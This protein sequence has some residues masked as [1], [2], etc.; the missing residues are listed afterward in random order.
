MFK[1]LKLKFIRTFCLV[2][3]VLMMCAGL[4][5]GAEKVTVTGARV[6]V[7]AIA[8]LQ[9]EIVGQV[10]RG[11]VLSATGERRNGMVEIIPPDS[12]AAWIYGELVIGDEVAA[13][14][15]RV[16]SGPGIGFRSIGKISKGFKVKVLETGGD[17]L[18]ISPPSSCTVWISAEFVSGKSG[19]AAVVP[20]EVAAENSGIAESSESVRRG[21]VVNS[22]SKPRPVAV[23]SQP[24]SIKPPV[25]PS[26]PV[27]DRRA[28]RPHVK[29]SSD[30]VIPVSPVKTVE[31]SKPAIVKS[32][33][34]TL[35]VV[36]KLKLVSRAP[37]GNPIVVCGVVRTS[38]FLPLRRPG[39]YRLVISGSNKAAKTG[40]YLIGDKAL[41]AGA[42]GKS[43]KVTGKKYWVQGVREPVVLV[44]EFCKPE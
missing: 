21:V 36:H 32:Q 7:R 19:E 25:S 5:Q 44:S 34:Q 11:D 31:L 24:H 1:G 28:P 20:V 6:N 12:V 39:S 27:V 4:C 17:W 40:C 38:G 10:V 29:H 43:V 13:S 3:A 8:D 2:S 37:Q 15:V 22:P 30:P 14:T 35:D 9:S 41:I 23:H 42:V 26:R 18:R 33:P 16:R